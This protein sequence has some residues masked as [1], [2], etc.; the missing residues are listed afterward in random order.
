LARCNTGTCGFCGGALVGNRFGAKFCS[1]PC[2]LKAGKRRRKIERGQFVSGEVAQCKECGKS[3]PKFSKKN[4]YCSQKCVSINAARRSKAPERIKSCIVC[5]AQFISKP[6]QITCSHA[7]KRIRLKQTKML[8]NYGLSQESLQEIMSRQGGGCAI[9][10]RTSPGVRLV[11]DHDH[12]CCAGLKSCGRCVR[13]I[14]CN[15]CNQALG[16]FGESVSRIKNAVEYLARA[17]RF[18][19]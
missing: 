1:A 19:I 10:L 4:T 15:Q 3:F 6:K 16:L 13:G 8:L 11:V 17:E 7:C 12:Q 5:S 9:C 18:R 14:L 2:R